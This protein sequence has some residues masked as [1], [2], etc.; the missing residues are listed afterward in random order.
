MLGSPCRRSEGRR[1]VRF[2]YLFTLLPPCG[3]HI[4][5]F[6]MTEKLWKITASSQCLPLDSFL[7]FQVS[8]AA[9]FSC[10]FSLKDGK[11]IPLFLALGFYSCFLSP[12]LHP[13][14][15]ASCNPFIALSLNHQI[16][17]CHL[18]PAGALTNTLEMVGAGLM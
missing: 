11:V 13:T 3:Q 12:S 10:S 2:G 9:S 4:L 7:R 18:F 17:G 14:S 5:D 8:G 16:L 15:M 6:S 1:N